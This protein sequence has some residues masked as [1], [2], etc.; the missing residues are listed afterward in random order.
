V[1]KASV[2]IEDDAADYYKAMKIKYEIAAKS[3]WLP[4]PIDPP[5]PPTTGWA[6]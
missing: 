3:P 4:V 1:R 6:R 2:K 5:K